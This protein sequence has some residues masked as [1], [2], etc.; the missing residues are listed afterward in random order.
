[1]K[2]SKL[3]GMAAMAAMMLGSCSTDEVVN[4]YSPENAIQ[5][6]TYVGRDAVSR[7]SII[8]TEGNTNADAGILSESLKEKG[9][10][11]FAYYTNE[12]S[13]INGD[14]PATTDVT[15]TGSPCNFTYNQLINL[16][17]NATDWSYSPIKYWPNDKADKLTFFAYAPYDDADETNNNNGYDN[18]KFNDLNTMN[19]DPIITFTVNGT[20]KNQTDLLFSKSDTKNLIKNKAGDGGIYVD[21]KVKFQFVHALARIGFTVKAITDEV[22]SGTPNPKGLDEATSIVLKKVIL[23][24]SAGSGDNAPTEGIFYTQG[25]LNLNQQDVNVT[26][27]SVI[28]NTYTQVAWTDIVGDEQNEDTQIFTL[29]KDNFATQTKGTED[30]YFNLYEGNGFILTEDEKILNAGNSTTANK[31]NADDS[32][33]MIIPQDL[34]TTGFYVYAEYDVITI[35]NNLGTD[36]QTYDGLKSKI[37]NHISTQV[38]GLNF[39]SGKAYTL[40]L[41]LGMTSVKV[42]ADVDNWTEVTPGTSVDLPQNT[43]GQQQQNP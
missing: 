31:L 35:D 30:T 4:D 37:T 12:S 22:T 13:Y 21:E 26:N 15:E 18:I 11:V 34:S 17:G 23:S 10:G 39:E 42:D 2:K 32:Y 5:F 16:T 40:N 29:T 14:D 6:G 43:Q 9:F 7:G 41:Q 27:T 24:K 28:P 8:T 19:G 33:I 1:M 20:V 25:K 36:N 3:F 38:T